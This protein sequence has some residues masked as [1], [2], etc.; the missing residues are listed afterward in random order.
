V[1]GNFV[2]EGV[3][4]RVGMEDGEVVGINV[5]E[6]VIGELVGESVGFEVGIEVGEV[7]GGLVG[8]KR[9]QH[10]PETDASECCLLPQVLL[11][12]HP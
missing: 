4:L 10:T 3:G 7:E 2:G 1:L 8:T 5:G 11:A 9:P 12:G 6:F